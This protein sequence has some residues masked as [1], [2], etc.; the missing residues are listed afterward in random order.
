MPTSDE[1][2]KNNN[3]NSIAVRNPQRGKSIRIKNP[4]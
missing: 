3:Q 1:T 2:W 4:K